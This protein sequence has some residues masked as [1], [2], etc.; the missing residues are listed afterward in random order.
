MHPECHA[1]RV[2]STPTTV[3]DAR[4]AYASIVVAALVVAAL[5]PTL[6]GRLVSPTSNGEP[7]T[8]E[9]AARSSTMEPRY[10]ANVLAMLWKLSTSSIIRVFRD[11]PGAAKIGRG[12]GAPQSPEL[13]NSADSPIGS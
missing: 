10:T 1:R 7:A 6:L 4:R 9:L 8:K 11:E 13:Y 2:R 3:L 5:K 12:Q